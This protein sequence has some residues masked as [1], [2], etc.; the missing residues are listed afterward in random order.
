[1]THCAIASRRRH[2][3]Q[4]SPN[5][6]ARALSSQHS[7]L[8]GVLAPSFDPGDAEV[9]EAI[10]ARLYAAGYA[11]LFAAT[12]GNGDRVVEAARAMA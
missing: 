6:T 2:T 4:V 10:Q 11:T 1:V 7:R 3:A 9:L 5:Q 8:A 12:G